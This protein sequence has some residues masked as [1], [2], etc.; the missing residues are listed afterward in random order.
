MDTQPK[1]ALAL[2]VAVAIL[3]LGLLM[4]WGYISS[5]K[6]A[7]SPVAGQAVTDVVNITGCEP[8]PQMVK[9]PAAAG[10]RITFK[11][12]DRRQHAIYFGI[13]NKYVIPANSK[14]LV[15]LGFFKTPGSMSYDCDQM[16]DVGRIYYKTQ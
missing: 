15:N 13:D 3:I 8:D 12:S 14:K 2:E 10:T 6:D 11:N 4:Y 5:I 1:K 16:K 7:R 9:L